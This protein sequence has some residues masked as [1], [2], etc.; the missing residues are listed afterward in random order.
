MALVPQRTRI[1]Q[2]ERGGVV[3]LSVLLR[4]S[5]SL[6]LFIHLFNKQ[7]YGAVEVWWK[8][9]KQIPKPQEI[10]S[11]RDVNKLSE[12]NGFEVSCYN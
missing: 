8:R 10:Y 4:L 2:G 3:I 7:L 5:H 9:K 1:R 12:T 11:L 6:T